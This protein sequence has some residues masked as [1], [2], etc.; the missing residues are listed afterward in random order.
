M[1]WIH[2]VYLGTEVKVFIL[3]VRYLIV[4]SDFEYDE[5]FRNQITK[6]EILF[7][8]LWTPLVKYS[9][10]NFFTKTVIQAIFTAQ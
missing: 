3:S 1:T 4:F 9:Y 2:L 8:D 7:F 6:I 5:Q 10:K